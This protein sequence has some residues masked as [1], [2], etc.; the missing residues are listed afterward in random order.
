MKDNFYITTPIFYVNDAPHIG[1]AYTSI[2]CDVISRFKKLQNINTRFLTGCDEHGQKV[3]SSAIKNNKTPQEFVDQ[4]SQT[5]QAMMDKLNISNDDFIRT[6]ETRHKESV[7]ALWNK[8]KENGSIYKG[9]YAGWYSMRDEAFYSE[10]ELTEDGKAPTGADVEWI[11]E[12]SYFFALSKW[13]DKLLDY[14]EKNEDFI[15][16]KSARKEVINFVKN[17]LTDLSISRTSF[18]WGINVP[19]DEEHVIYVWLDALT[20]YISA[21]GYPEKTQQLNDYWPAT[22]VIGKDILRFH[23]IYWPAFL[24]AANIQLPQKIVSHGWWTNDGEKISKSLGN[25]I[26]PIELVNQYGLDPVRYFLMKEITF[27][28]DGNFSH[29]NLVSRVN[30]ELANKVGNLLQRTCSFAFKHCNKAL[31]DISTTDID[32]IYNI[33]LITKAQKTIKLCIS[34]MDQYNISQVLEHIITLAEDANAYIDQEA[35]WSLKKTNPK[36][37]QQILYTLLELMRYIGIMLQPFVPDAANKIL[38]QLQVKQNQRKL[39]HLKR[40]YAL[41]SGA[42]ID[43][44]E[45]IFPRIE[46]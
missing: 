9:K 19:G 26:D 34:E 41:T 6:T 11:E 2:T 8:L 30:S 40:E 44:P 39:E 37:M 45:P 24:M 1:H 38:N 43:A 13:Q 10:K 21:L 27:G 46:K 31:P 36:K 7:K 25:T 23:A 29:D 14:Y 28:K 4:Y 15:Y 3:E 17:G 42:T 20:N 35:P 22:H 12:S 18:K 5:F 33:S 16:P 32:A